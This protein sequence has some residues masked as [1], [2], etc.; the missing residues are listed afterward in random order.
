MLCVASVT[1]LTLSIIA[2][3][4]IL[5]HPPSGPV[6]RAARYTALKCTP[7]SPRTTFTAV[8][9]PPK[10]SP[11][12]TAPLAQR[13][14]LAEADL[15][16]LDGCIAQFDAMVSAATTRGYTST[17]TALVGRQTASRAAPV[18]ERQQAAGG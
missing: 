13:I 16:D 15:R 5:H 10:R 8:A 1:A 17:A 3:C 12:S 14:A 18:A 11:R 2:D 6:G 4:S 7:K 9:T